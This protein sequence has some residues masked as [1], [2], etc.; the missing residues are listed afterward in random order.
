M[1][2][3]AF[4]KQKPTHIAGTFLNEMIYSNCS[5]RSREV[6]V[7]ITAAV[8]AARFLRTAKRLWPL[9]RGCAPQNWAGENGGCLFLSTFSSK[10]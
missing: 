10:E 3:L 2:A 9:P 8:K 5:S 6:A 4:G 7:P 1:P